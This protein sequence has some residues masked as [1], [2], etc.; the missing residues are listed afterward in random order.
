MLKA[1]GKKTGHSLGDME[2]YWDSGKDAAQRKG[3]KP[4]STAF[5]KYANAVTQRRSGNKSKA[6]ESFLERIDQRI[7]AETSEVRLGPSGERF[8]A[9]GANKA[10]ERNLYGPGMTQAGKMTN[11]GQ[12]NITG[13]GD[14]EEPKKPHI[15]KMIGWEV[16]YED[17]TTGKPTGGQWF[18]RAEEDLPC[19]MCGQSGRIEITPT[20]EKG[21]ICTKCHG[22]GWRNKRVEDYARSLSASGR[23]PVIRPARGKPTN[24]RFPKAGEAF[25][26][27]PEPSLGY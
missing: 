20:N 16:S 8:Q 10:G 23:R 11:T 19:H 27:A 21:I 22:V 3:L 14:L 2:R 4:K 12:A 25:G 9:G 26:T 13:A 7:F 18:P 17:P 15:P 5:Y 1:V 6:E 24:Q